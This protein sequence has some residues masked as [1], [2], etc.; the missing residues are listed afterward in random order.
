MKRFTVI[1]ILILAIIL[2]LGG[3]V[4][5]QKNELKIKGEITSEN[6]YA[7]IIIELA[8]AP[9]SVY[10]KSLIYKV[11][12]FF[13]RN[14]GLSYESRILDRQ[15]S[16]NDLIVSMGGK[17]TL[18]FTETFN[19]FACVVPIEKVKELEK[20][21]GIKSIYPDSEA[22]LERTFLTKTIHSD[23]VN[24]AKD[25]YGNLVT[26]KNIVVGIVDTGVDYTHTELGGGKFPNSKVVGGYD[27]ADND[28]DPMDEEG[29][30]T[31]IAGIIAGSKLGVAP[32]AK[33]MIYKVFKKTDSTT[34]TSL[35]VKG[36]DQAV[37]DK[38]NIINI[39]IGVT[40]GLGDGS[41]P[42]A[43]SVKNAVNSGVIVVAAAG[44]KGTRSEVV[45]Y[46][47][48]APSS[49]AEAI[50]VGASEDGQTGVLNVADKE[51]LGTYPAESPIFSEGSF[52]IVYCGI[53]EKSDFQGKDLKGKIALIERGKIYFGDKDLN[54]KANGAIGVIVYNNVSGMPKIQLVSQD[55]PIEKNFIPFLFV[56]YTDGMLLREFISEKLTVANKYGLGRIADFT[57]SGPT[58]DFV[59][60]PD[61]VAPGININ[62]TYLGGDYMTMSGTSMSSPVVAGVCA[63]VKQAKPGLTPQEVKSLLMNTAD[64]LLNTDS[65]MPYPPYLQGAGR[66]NALSAFNSSIIV[67]PSSLL[68]GNGE[69]AKTFS[70]SIKNLSGNTKILSLSI[71]YSSN[72]TLTISAPS[73]L[74]IMPNKESNI[75][76]SMTASN[77]TLESHGFISFNDASTSYHISFL[78]MKNTNVRDLLYAE[79]ASGNTVTALQ[80]I[81]VKFSV[82]QGMEITDESSTFR[83]NIAEEVKVSLFDSRGK[84]LGTIFDKSPISVGDYKSSIQA[85]SDR[86]GLYFLQDGTYY[87]KIEYLEA[88]ENEA[89]KDILKTI[90]KYSSS[91]S[92]TVLGTPKGE[93]RLLMQN[94]LTPSIKAGSQFTI[95]LSVAKLPSTQSLSFDII[96]DRLRLLPVNIA[97]GD[98]LSQDTLFN[99]VLSEGKVSIYLSFPTSIALSSG[100]VAFITF[101]ALESGNETIEI[102]NVS[103]ISRDSFVAVPLA[104]SISNYSQIYDIN[105]DRAV[106]YADFQLL[107]MHFG[108]KSTD[109]S[110][111]K[112]SDLNFDGSINDLDLFIFAKHYGERYP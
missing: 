27:F 48:S 32:D 100:N 108:E 26:G 20:L 23:A 58:E 57:S 8:D 82:G 7:K 12:N 65:G 55:S 29:H 75:N 54:A 94:N 10:R 87:Y 16:L 103:P 83:G 51:I 74:T 41:D 105:G 80:G 96:F 47:I 28:P 88:N 99:Y 2:S 60:K 46:P 109:S 49:T 5:A 4:N 37:K 39:S 112:Q 63:L 106:D 14:D 90:T 35:I 18:N 76:I 42:Q 33:I 85:F 67:K 44:N 9:V 1:F 101:K 110:F 36:I 3:S 31:H 72:D 43:I 15:V 64:V 69:A 78:Y 62:S 6:G 68:F 81:D 61:L 93:M 59:F 89:N 45:Q 102:S 11:E 104:C 71:K 70:I 56:S 17:L 66:V 34:S 25:S 84:Y 73:T 86:S 40:G 50:S 107:K 91:G 22:V 19:G 24:Q 21:P 92:F 95:V 98:G 38:V 52:D 30:G 79:K 77:E 13:V 111:F 97:K 53:G